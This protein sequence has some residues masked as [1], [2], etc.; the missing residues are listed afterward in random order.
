MRRATLRGIV[1]GLL[2]SL[3]GAACDPGGTA[4]NSATAVW[5]PE[6]T[7]V[8]ADILG[9]PGTLTN[10]WADI[11]GD[12]D[13]DLFIGFNGSPNRLYRNDNG[14][15]VDVASEL[16]LAE[17]RS[18]RT[19]AWGDFDSD[20][21]PD[22]FL[23]YPRRR[24]DER[25]VTKL[26]RNDGS[27]FVEVAA[28]VGLQV[29][30]GS[31]RQ[32]SWIDY[33]ADGD[34]D[35]FLAL[36]DLP[37]P[38]FENDGGTFRDVAAE[39]GLGDPRRTV[40]AVWFDYEQ[41]G[42]LDLFVANMDGDPNG[43]FRNDGGIF[44]DVAAEAGVAD[45]G[46]G[47]GDESLGTVRPCVTDYDN[48]GLFDIF[49]ANYG[50]NAL[51]HNEGDGTFRDVAPEFGLNIDARYDTCEFGDYDHDGRVDLY[52]NGTVTGGTQYRDYLFRNTSDGFQDVTPPELLGLDA[53]HGAQWV[54]FD[55]DGALD[56]SLT[57]VTET[58]MH[59]VMR[60]LMGAEL[61]ARSIQVRVVD[62]R[63]HA[64]KAGAEVRLYTAGTRTLLG[65]R[66]LD[67]GSGYD[68]QSVLPVHFGLGG[69]GPV[70]IEVLFPGNGSRAVTRLTNVEPADH[71][72]Q[73]LTV[74]LPE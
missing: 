9:E 19:S 42:D 7:P 12:G 13:S 26:Y 47:L 2:V 20:G 24:G 10:A 69:E 11:D 3:V 55:Q 53:D 68:S 63:G 32:A 1:G 18:T 4:T 71:T 34:L 58:G 8:Q 15:L 59:H 48:D 39:V 33:D 40:G 70:D 57:G 16:G 23:G 46:R 30:E 56:L 43:L 65:T 62:S 14:V 27:S 51:Y 17:E 74:M 45:G 36:R 31:T 37:N 72:G 67:T 52:V 49:L 64:T 73:S 41:D 66:I 61:K 28:A 44:T 5:S 50:P 29:A 6:F 25:P 38:L 60:N 54:D 21:D 22:L 35:L